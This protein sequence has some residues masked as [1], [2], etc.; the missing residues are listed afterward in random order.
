MERFVLKLAK[1]IPPHLGDKILYPGLSLENAE[2]AMLLIH[3]RGATAE[4]MLPLID[5]LE[6]D[7]ISF[8]IPQ[9]DQLTWYPYRFIEERQANEPGITS[10]LTLIH[11]I[12]QSLEDK[13]FPKHKIYLLGFSQ[14]ACLAADYVARFPAQFAGVFILSGGLIG[15][16]LKA[17]DYAGHLENTPVFLGCSTEDFHIPENRVYESARVFESLKAKVTKKIYENLGHTIN[18]DEIDEINHIVK[19]R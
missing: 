15:K 5:A 14:G 16:S 18:Q 1:T 10:G 2:F 11:T 9:A 3:G 13:G 17:N 4:S 7:K 19:Y 8:V 12:I 6:A